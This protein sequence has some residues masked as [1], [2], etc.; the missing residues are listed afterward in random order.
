MA[1]ELIA[2]ITSGDLKGN[3]VSSGI[4]IFY[5]DVSQL[6]SEQ[7]AL[8]KGPAGPQGEPGK[9]GVQGPRGLAGPQGNPGPQ[10]QPGPAGK[11]W[12]KYAVDKPT[13]DSQM[14]DE[15]N[16]NCKYLG[17]SNGN[18]STAPTSYLEYTWMRIVGTG[19]GT[20]DVTNT[21]LEAAINDAITTDTWSGLNTANKTVQGSINELKT[22]VDNMSTSGG[23]MNSSQVLALIIDTI[24]NH[25]FNGL[26]TTNK[27]VIGGINEA[28]I[29]GGSSSSAVY[30]TPSVDG[31]GN[32]SW[33]NNG[34]LTNPTSVNIKGPKGDN[35]TDGKNGK[36]GVTF[37]PSV[38]SEGNL[39]W[40]NN[41]ELNNP[42]TVNIKGATGQKGEAG[43][44]GFSPSIS[45]EEITDGHKVTITNENS[46]DSFNIMNGTNGNNGQD[47]VSP[48]IVLDTS[49][50]GR[51]GVSIDVTDASGVKSAFVNNG[52][53]FTPSVNNNGELSW[54]NNGGLDNPTTVNIKGPIG[55]PGINQLTYIGTKYLT[56]S[57]A[58]NK[59]NIDNVNTDLNLPSG[60]DFFASSDTR[61]K[62]MPVIAVAR[63]TDDSKH[64][65][66]TTSFESGSALD[67]SAVYSVINKVMVDGATF[68]PS[69]SAD[70]NLSWTNN[71]SLANPTTVNIKGP[72][73]IQGERGFSPTI[74]NEVIDGGNKVTINNE[75]SSSSFN[76]MDGEPLEYHGPALANININNNVTI[77]LTNFNRTP[78]SG[79][80]VLALNNMSTVG[81]NISISV[82][83]FVS[84]NSSNAVFKVSYSYSIRGEKGN[85]G[86]KGNP[87][88][89]GYSPTI[90]VE[91]VT[92]NQGGK[93]LTINNKDSSTSDNIMNGVTFIPKVTT[94]SSSSILS[95]TNNGGLSNPSQ[96]NITGKSGIIYSADEPTDKDVIWAQEITDTVNNDYFIQGRGVA[97]I[98]IVDAYPATEEP[99]VL[100]L[101]KQS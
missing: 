30:F 73:G 25:T 10:G 76:I 67:K 13:N 93:K 70:G 68:T 66:V 1:N 101:L 36:D 74:S 49:T 57:N 45:V 16:E 65:I 22:T 4:S 46:S 91:D 48:T 27:T 14:L 84:A 85:T 37:T 29:T 19:S 100:Y 15:Y 44:D 95:W 28:A 26:N 5:V 69:V 39:S 38:D 11:V 51:G 56:F 97:R 60:V 59:I 75:T 80:S 2:N 64:Y 42:T 71:N 41:G 23:G 53:T 31:E 87:G 63:N 81:T 90:S 3:L 20:G 33:T 34:S 50:T 61:Y 58:Y 83:T 92:T 43:K 8:V 96:V 47:G 98:E 79:D 86:E 89:D 77:P 99:N 12:F 78:K 55:N 6:T 54:T 72:Q 35:G 17:L 9:N 88:N 40:T 21:E 94:N 18:T 62:E 52:T 82:L 24:T 32:L 7:L